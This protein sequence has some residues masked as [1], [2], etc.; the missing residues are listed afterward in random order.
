MYL[1]DTNIFLEGLLEQEKAESVRSF[2]QAVDL[3]RIF[4]TDFSLHSIS[5]VLFRLGEY[6]LFISFFNDMIIDGMEILS[7]NPVDMMKLEVAAQRFGLDFDDAYQYQAAEKYQMQLISFDRDF[8]RTDKGRK[9]P[10]EV[11]L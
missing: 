9:E 5:I 7:L 2:F 1:T 11:M 10:S 6:E 3:D 8:D 4:I